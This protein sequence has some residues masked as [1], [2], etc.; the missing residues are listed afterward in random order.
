[1]LMLL[2]DVQLTLKCEPLFWHYTCHSHIMTSIIGALIDD[3]CRQ[4]FCVKNF[5]HIAQI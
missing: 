2:S 1:M 3:G 5:G 4:K